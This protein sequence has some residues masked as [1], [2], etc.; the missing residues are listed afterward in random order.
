[1]T[2]NTTDIAV[3]FPA[4]A[5]ANLVPADS[6]PLTF[7]SSGQTL[8]AY[9]IGKTDVEEDHLRSLS[10]TRI[11]A[12]ISLALFLVSLSRAGAATLALNTRGA[13]PS[14]Q[15][16]GHAMKRIMA[17]SKCCGGSPLCGR[18]CFYLRV[19]L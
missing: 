7:G 12:R 17:L 9:V 19:F 1:M 16:S 6:K 14:Q 18:V 15:M 2:R 5:P 3:T 4:L 13:Y 11:T 10:P 8:K